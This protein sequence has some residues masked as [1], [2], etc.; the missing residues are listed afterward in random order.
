MPTYRR[1]EHLNHK[2]PLIE[3]D[4]IKKGAVTTDKISD[5]AVTTEKLANGAVTSEKIANGAVT[6]DKLAP[7]SVRQIAGLEEGLS[8]LIEQAGDAIEATND[9]TALAREVATHPT[10][11]D[12][13]GWVWEYDLERHEMVK[14]DK[15][16]VGKPGRDGRDGQDGQSGQSGQ[17][18]QDGQ[19][20]QN[21][22][23]SPSCSCPKIYILTESAYAA[24]ST[25]ETGALYF[26]TADVSESSNVFG[27]NLPIILGGGATASAVLGG[28]LPITLN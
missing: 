25:K 8:G 16:I 26:L 1:D 3:T 13:D 7:E 14:T 22:Q 21:G 2:V 6:R 20:G 27:G 15:Q 28:N 11:I 12:A 19:D 18:G 10:T 24:L 4:D 5:G 9:A 17:D 23:G